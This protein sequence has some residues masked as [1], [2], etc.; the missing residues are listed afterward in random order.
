MSGTLRVLIAEP[1]VLVADGLRALLEDA[2]GFCVAAAISDLSI[3]DE[4]LRISDADIAIVNP[5]LVDSRCAH[6]LKNFF[7]SLQSVKTLAIIY[8]VFDD[9][10]LRQ[11]DAVAKIVDSPSSIVAKLRHIVTEDAEGR[12]ENTYELTERERDIL[13]SV[14]RGR[15]NKEIADEYNISIHTV[16]SHRKNITRKTGIKSVAG[17][18]VYA[19]LNNLISK[20]DIE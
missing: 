7:P 9:E 11:F 19:L 5:S 4:R 2:G 14:A 8:G 20:N 17:L 10:L 18:T 1:S 13:M 15:T 6:N 3:L 12:S 16:I